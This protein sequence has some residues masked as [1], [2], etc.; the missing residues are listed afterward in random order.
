MPWF[1]VNYAQNAFLRVLASKGWALETLSVEQGNT[2]ML[3]FYRDYRPQH[4]GE[5]ALEHSHV[6]GAMSIARHMTH[7]DTGATHVLT[8]TV[9]A[10][11]GHLSFV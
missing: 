7:R 8:L 10:A 2:A 5:D 1:R 4:G 9:D 11:G 6:D 3:E